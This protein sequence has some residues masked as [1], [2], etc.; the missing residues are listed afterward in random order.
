LL[1]GWAEFDSE[2]REFESLRAREFSGQS[3]SD[4]AA[5]GSRRYLPWIFSPLG[6]TLICRPSGCFFVW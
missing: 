2:G 3:F 4:L 5:A 1:V 6:P